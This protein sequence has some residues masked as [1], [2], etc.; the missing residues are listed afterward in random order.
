VIPY[1]QIPAE[2]R[3]IG[4]FTG[5]IGDHN[6]VLG[7]ALAQWMARDDTKA[8]PNV[9]RAANTAM[10]AIDAM[11][12]ELHQLRAQLSAE[13]RASDDA[14]AVRVDELLRSRTERGEQMEIYVRLMPDVKALVLALTL[15]PGHCLHAALVSNLPDTTTTRDVPHVTD[16]L[17]LGERPG[18][19]VVQLGA[20]V[21]PGSVMLRDSFLLCCHA[22]APVR[23]FQDVAE[24]HLAGV[25]LHEHVQ[26]RA[27][28]IST[29]GKRSSC[30]IFSCGSHW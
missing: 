30:F 5:R 6:G 26:H 18:A 8:E 28:E 16:V 19:S 12:G 11:L 9:R 24:G 25:A 1:D 7:V 17:Q 14:A 20:L 21:P 13:I 23:A 15:L 22:H 29:S 27:E 4:D 10:D 2:R 3:T